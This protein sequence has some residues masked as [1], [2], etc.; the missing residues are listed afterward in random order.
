MRS[1]WKTFHIRDLG[2]CR[3]GVSYKSPDDLRQ[4]ENDATIPGRGG[5]LCNRG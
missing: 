2:E 5:I 3:R 4:D 1:E